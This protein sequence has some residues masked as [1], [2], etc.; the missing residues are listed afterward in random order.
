MT[1]CTRHREHLAARAGA[2]ASFFPDA[3]LAAHLAICPE[4]R[5]FATELENLTR[6]LE[7]TAVSLPEPLLSP[8]V[9]RTVAKAIRNRRRERIAAIAWS[10]TL[11]GAAA[12][13]ALIIGNP[14]SEK[15]SRSTQLSSTQHSTETARHA[16]VEPNLSRYQSAFRRSA[17]SLD[18]LLDDGAV[19]APTS[20][21]TE[22]F[23]SLRLGSRM[24]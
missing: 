17:E 20:S 10:I 18:A 12:A 19:E 1:A 9:R 13:F 2:D 7:T 3:S 11:A 21:A 16:V 4:C 23:A 15:R 6:E 14:H 8:R 5:Q 22:T 24:E